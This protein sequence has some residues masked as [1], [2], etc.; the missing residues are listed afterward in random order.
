MSK[1]IRMINNVF[2][3]QNPREVKSKDNI[4]GYFLVNQGLYDDIEITKENIFEFGG[5][6]I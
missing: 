4:F 1:G 2:E 6:G 3:Q 5:F